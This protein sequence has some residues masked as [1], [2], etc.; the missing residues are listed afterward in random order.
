MLDFYRSHKPTLQLFDDVPQV[1]G[2]IA[3]AVLVSIMNAANEA[4][5]ETRCDGVNAELCRLPIFVQVFERIM[6]SDNSRA[7]SVH[8]NVDPVLSSFGSS[9]SAAMASILHCIGEIFRVY[10]FAF[11]D[12]YPTSHAARV[13]YHQV[14]GG[15]YTNNWL[16]RSWG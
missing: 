5:D 6:L 11:S 14:T 1:L 15:C 2:A 4:L 12:T 16:L 8:V 10:E 9:M 3:H 7:N 13:N